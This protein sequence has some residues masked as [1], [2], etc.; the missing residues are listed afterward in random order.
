MSKDDG[1]LTLDGRVTPLMELLLRRRSYRK[2]D[3]RPAPEEAVGYVLGCARRFQERCGFAA[4][5][6]AA[7]PRGPAFERVIRAATRGLVG[8]V[9]PWLSSTRAS[10]LL[11]CAVVY[12]GQG[13]GP[14][15]EPRGRSLELVLEQ[16]AMTMQIAVLAATEVGCATCWLAGINHERVEEAHQLDDGARL[17]AISTLGRPPERMGFSWDAIGHHL[18][19]KRRRPLEELWMPERWR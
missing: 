9:N 6:I 10:H 5:R 16:A 4:P 17:I 13:G 18:I 1:S 2:Y 14:G 8:M 11:L 7:V 12:P 19:S 15:T 3:A